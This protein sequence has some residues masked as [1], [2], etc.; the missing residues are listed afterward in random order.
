M[1]FPSCTFSKL[2]SFRFTKLPSRHP[3]PFLD[4]KVPFSTS[5]VPFLTDE[6]LASVGGKDL[7]LAQWAR[8]RCRCRPPDGRI[9]RASRRKG[10]ILAQWARKRCCCRCGLS[11]SLSLSPSLPKALSPLGQPSRHG[12]RVSH[13]SSKERLHLITAIASAIHVPHRGNSR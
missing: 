9:P 3:S 7:I 6:Y 1:E 5:K 12:L 8:K 10:P 11:L 4:I 2:H 13:H